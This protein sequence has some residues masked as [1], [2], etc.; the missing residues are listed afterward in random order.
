[1]FYISTE[2]Q[3]QLA[4]W[5]AVTFQIYLSPWLL[6]S[7][8]LCEL[9]VCTSPISPC[10]HRNSFPTTQ[11]KWV[12]PSC[13]SRTFVSKSTLPRVYHITSRLQVCFKQVGEKSP[14]LYVLSHPYHSHN[15]WILITQDR[16]WRV[17]LHSCDRLHLVQDVNNL[18]SDYITKSVLIVTKELFIWF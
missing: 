15:A 12:E 2:F 1:M 16:Q 6:P 18:W 3:C 17:I 7:S 10:L 8:P 11:P 14:S 5:L 9:C 13:L 4:C